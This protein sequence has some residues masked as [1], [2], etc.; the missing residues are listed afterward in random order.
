MLLADQD[1]LYDPTD[2]ND[3]L[4]LGLHG[5]HE[6]GGAARSCGPDVPGQ[7]EQGP[8]RRAVPRT[9]PI[10]YVRSPRAAV[11]LDPDEQVRDVVRLIFDKFDELGT[12]SACSA[13]W[14]ATASAWA[15]ARTPAPTG[16]DWSGGGRTGRRLSATCC[17]TRATPG[18]TGSAT[19]RP[20]RGG[21]P[22]RP[23]TG[24]RGPCRRRS[25]WC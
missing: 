11:D 3:R 23:A 6:R 24:T 9:S 10:G 14:S 2:H 20:T 7:A 5:D 15:S 4:L 18:P 16:A 21:G 17:T 13:T 19:G 1:G 12:A 25:A 8:P 22:G